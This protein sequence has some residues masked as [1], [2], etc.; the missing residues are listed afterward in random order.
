MARFSALVGVALAL[1][2]VIA[3]CGNALK[4]GDY[5]IYKMD[6]QGATKGT[7]CY[8]V[9]G[10]DP[11]TKSDTDTSLASATWVM[12]TDASGNYFLDLG[13]NTLQGKETDTGIGFGATKVDVEYDM[14][15]VTQTKRTATIDVKINVTIDGKSIGGTGVTTSSFTCS[16]MTCTTAIPS[17]TVTQAF[18]GTEVD[19]VDLQYTVK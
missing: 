5:R 14:D 17:C 16:G 8:P 12:T 15:D 10:P 4:P 9:T 6:F 7:G 3:G 13:A 2:P 19:E 18:S 11:N 1:A